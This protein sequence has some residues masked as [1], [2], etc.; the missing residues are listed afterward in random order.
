MF[1]INNLLDFITTQKYTDAIGKLTNI[2]GVELKPIDS[3][4]ISVE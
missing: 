1:K 2:S 4:N 3:K